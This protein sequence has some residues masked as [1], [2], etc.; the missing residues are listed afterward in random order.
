V[1]DLT[2]EAWDKVL[3]LNLKSDFLFCK[4]VVPYKFRN[5]LRTKMYLHFLE[6]VG[7]ESSIKLA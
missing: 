5:E 6:H 7:K 3:A 1:E 2:E 4:F